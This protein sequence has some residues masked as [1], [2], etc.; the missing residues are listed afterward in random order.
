MAVLQPFIELRLGRAGLLPSVEPR[1]LLAHLDRDDRVPVVDK[2]SPVL[3]EVSALSD[4]LAHQRASIARGLR[5]SSWRRYSRPTASSSFS[6][7]SAEQRPRL[8]A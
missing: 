4:C 6:A 3:G 5:R 1:G 2:R 8:I 7:T